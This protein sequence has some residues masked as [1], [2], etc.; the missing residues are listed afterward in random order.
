MAADHVTAELHRLARQQQASQHAAQHR[1]GAAP[2]M[3]AAAALGLPLA[4]QVMTSEDA[5]AFITSL[6]PELA[7]ELTRGRGLPRAPSDPG[8]ASR[9]AAVG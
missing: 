8:R 4:V 6:T 3:A 5:T 7:A 1:V 9:L 2:R